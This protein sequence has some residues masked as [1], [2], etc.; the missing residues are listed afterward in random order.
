MGVEGR[1]RFRVLR[2]LVSGLQFRALG[3]QV[4]RTEGMESTADS[5]C[6]LKRPVGEGKVWGLGFRV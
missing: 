2:V 3:L 6:M 4:F 5:K 1:Y